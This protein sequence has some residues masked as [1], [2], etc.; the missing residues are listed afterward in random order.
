MSKLIS[1]L[2]K[3]H[4]VIGPNLIENN[5]YKFKQITSE[6]ELYLNHK[7]TILPPKKYFMPQYET[8]LTYD[9]SSGQHMQA[10][11]ETQPL[12]LIGVHTCDIEG[13][14]CLNIVFSDRPRDIHF[15][16]R[17]NDITIIGI[18]CLRY[19]DEYACCKSMKTNSPKNGYDIFFTELSTSYYV[20]IYT[21][22]GE[23]I[24]NNRDIFRDVSPI[25]KEEYERIIAEKNNNFDY[26]IPIRYHDIP[27]LFN[28]TSESRIWEKIGNKCLSCGNCTNVCPT[29]YC[30][31]VRDEP[32]LNLKT[33]KRLRIWD[34]CQNESF[35]K[36]AGGES[37][38]E[39]RSDRKK[40]RFHRKFNYPY[41]RYGRLF[42]TGCGRCSRACMAD[43]SLK[44]TILELIEERG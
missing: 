4:I 1:F 14:Q 23:E 18:E 38:R 16:T 26:E 33:G 31:D 39:K 32:D 8:L 9:T 42:C 30:F 44:Q 11:V 25:E 19:C 13:L 22:K 3:S 24:V 7:P 28:E 10:V 35:A 41:N 36:V 6:N 17:K 37:F 12:A 34:S 29:C 2:N 21:D 5:E 43:I 27:R 15:L 40:H 20:D